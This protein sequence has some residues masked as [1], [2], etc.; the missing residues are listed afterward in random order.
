MTLL[1]PLIGAIVGAAGGFAIGEMM[2]IGIGGSAFDARFLTM[3]IGAIIGY[4]G[5]RIFAGRSADN[6][7][8]EV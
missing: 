2:Q 3:M 8:E 5:G 6:H 7:H 1:L 4:F